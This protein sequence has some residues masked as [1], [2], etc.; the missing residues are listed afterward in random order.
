MQDQGTATSSPDTCISQVAMRTSGDTGKQSPSESESII[1]R[2]AGLSVSTG[3]NSDGERKLTTPKRKWMLLW[4]AQQGAIVENEQPRIPSTTD[5]AASASAAQPPATTYP[6]EPS[7]VEATV[8]ASEATAEPSTE[9]PVDRTTTSIEEAAVVAEDGEILA[10]DVTQAQ[11]PSQPPTVAAGV[12]RVTMLHV[13]GSSTLSPSG[14]HSSPTATST[15]ISPSA[16]AKETD[17]RTPSPTTTLTKAASTTQLMEPK[18]SLEATFVNKTESTCVN[19]AAPGKRKLPEFESTAAAEEDDDMIELTESERQRLERRRAKKS[20]WDEGD[21]RKHGGSLDLAALDRLSSTNTPASHPASF[22]KFPRQRPAFR[23]S[24]SLDT[25]ELPFRYRSSF[26]ATVNA[27]LQSIVPASTT[28]Q[29]P[30]R[31]LN[32]SASLPIDRSRPPPRP[33]SRYLPPSEN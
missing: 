4:S 18:A 9:T 22:A 24:Q 13:V 29:A 32:Q 1:V 30:R 14:E 20:K 16:K 25:K 6:V 11:V 21:P 5:A 10:G 7:T 28:S 23:H 8:E 17:G 33:S 2:G 3:V 31:T 15:S 27:A 12:L 19:V 26:R